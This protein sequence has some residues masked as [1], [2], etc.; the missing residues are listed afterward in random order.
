MKKNKKPKV[1]IIM[2]I[3]NCEKYLEES[4]E[5]ILKQ[6]YENWELIMCDDGSSDNTLKIA[7][8][9]QEKYP[10]KIIVIKNNKNMGLNFT[11]NKCIEYVSGEYIARQDGDDLSLTNRLE[12][13][14]DFLINNPK[15][16]LVSANMIYFDDFGDWGC[17]HNFGEVK[18]ENFIKGSPICHAPCV[19]KTDVLKSVGGYSVDDKLLRV[20]DYHLWFKLY[21]AGYKCY[22]LKECLYKMRDDENA[23]KR[24]N[25]KNRLNETRL[26]LWGFKKLG[27]RL[28]D[29]VWAFKP[30]IAYITPKFLYQKVH[31]KNTDGNFDN[32]KKIK[33]AQFVGSMN[34]GGTETM[35]MNLLKYLDKEKYEFVFIENVKEK[36]WYSDEIEKLGGSIIKIQNFS[37]KNIFSYIRELKFVFKKEKFDVIHSHTFLHSGIVLY[38]AKKAK[39]KIRI[40][41]SHSAMRA[42]DNGFI[43]KCFL[44]YLLNKYSNVKIACST[45]AGICLFGKKFKKLGKVLPNPIELSLYK[46]NDKVKEK[47]RERY[48]INNKTFIIGHVGRL[49]EVKNHNFM[50]HIADELKRKKF[51]FKLFFVGDGDLKE[52]IKKEIKQKELENNIIM[53]GNVNNVNEYMQLFD[54]LLLPSF[55]EGLPVTLV[56]SQASNLFAYVSN[57]VS[58]EA[59]FNLGL[60]EFLDINDVKLWT[61]KIINYKKKDIKYDKIKESL[62]N[63]NF[64]VAKT[65]KIYE[66]IYVT[67]GSNEK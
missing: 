46:N 7:L 66:D 10:K 61:N 50:L 47:L 24:R 63:K 26:K 57:N 19:I 65:I 41:H 34:C 49:V 20:E 43:K 54:L 45:E 28:I 39:I 60:I 53:T 42:E 22:N 32:H 48:S 1:S 16:D 35:L 67:G 21:L 8:Q 9:Y 6:T 13:E 64:D 15:Y 33:V 25:F 11:L 23:Y 38:A 5:S 27:I 3:Y 18:K 51:D 2:G 44:Q 40:A 59:D 4:I 29:Y 55:Y 14:I 12:T 17:S 52:E 30:I 37:M 56:E 31:R 36:S 58:R 62:Q